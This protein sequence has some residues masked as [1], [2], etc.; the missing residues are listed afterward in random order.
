VASRRDNA[1]PGTEWFFGLTA[2]NAV[3]SRGDHKGEE[4]K[5]SYHNSRAPT[6]TAAW[7]DELLK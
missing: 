7:I 2:Q 6:F 3:N 1:N 5:A 4:W